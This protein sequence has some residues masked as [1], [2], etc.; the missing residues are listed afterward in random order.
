MKK[1]SLIK[2]YIFLI[3]FIVKDS[4]PQ[5]IQVG[6]FGGV[7]TTTILVQGTNLFVSTSGNGVFKSSD[8]G[9]TWN[10]A[11]LSTLSIIA[12]AASDSFL[13]AGTNSIP[14]NIYIS[15]NK[16][17]TWNPAGLTDI[18]FGSFLINGNNIYAGT[19]FFSG[20]I[21]LSSNNGRNWIKVNRD[22]VYDINSLIIKNPNL[23]FA[24]T[25]AGV[26]LSTNDGENWTPVNNGLPDIGVS[27]LFVKD[28]LIFA[29]TRGVG[30]FLSSN[31]GANWTDANNGLT[32]LDISAFEVSNNKLFAATR[33]DI[34]SLSDVFFSSDNG[35]NWSYTNLWVR[36]VYSLAINNNFIF[37][38]GGVGGIYRG[39][40]SE[41][42]SVDDELNILPSVSFLEQ[43]YP[44]PFNPTT[45]ISWNSPVSSWQ[46]LK[47]YDVLGNEVAT[48]VDEYKPAGSYEVEFQSTLDNRK[49][50]S[51][52]YYYQLKTGKFSQ[53]KKLILAR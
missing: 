16:G 18:Y 29:G 14:G 13:F 9:A 3:L 51:G 46:T 40:I 39:L 24:G 34:F 19:I 17:D 43:N 32:I 27:A 15:S 12:L 52:V 45:K 33:A 7:A 49:L 41:I 25:E 5:W 22:S 8:N 4:F 48:L 11:G 26:F 36:T 35:T 2:I 53:T 6:S 38:G 31:N 28:S 20:G 21:Y 47:I 1:H 23:L 30:V 10:S 50:A 42:T 44:N 37:A